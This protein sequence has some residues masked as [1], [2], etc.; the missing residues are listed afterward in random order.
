M[1]KNPTH[2]K[3]T[4]KVRGRHSETRPQQVI[5]VRHLSGGNEA[6]KKR[7]KVTVDYPRTRQAKDYKQL[8]LL[9]SRDQ[10]FDTYL[11]TLDRLNAWA[12]GDV[13]AYFNLNERHGHREKMVKLLTKARNEISE[14]LIQLD[15]AIN[16]TT[17]L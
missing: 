6:K 14:Q 8:D 16:S 4:G 15:D 3:E 2:A 11:N 5:S 17:A 9:Q 7:Q 10:L 1:K 12:N 13:H